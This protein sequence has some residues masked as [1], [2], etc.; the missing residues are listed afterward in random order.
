MARPKW[1]PI[2]LGIA[3]FVFI[4]GAGIVGTGIYL[5][6]RQVSMTS[7]TTEDPE[8][9]FAEARSKLA[10][11]KPYIEFEENDLE[12]KPIVHRENEREGRPPLNNLHVLIW[13]EREHKLVRLTLPFWIV[14]LGRSGDLRL[15]P[16]QTGM[17]DG[18]RL[19]V[20][21][22]D[23]ERNGP[24]LVLDVKGR[25]GERLLVWVD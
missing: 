16:E 14:R 23:L 21:A 18:L 13:D 15:D 17:R 12:S 3:I 2:A 19:S 6:S 11:Q 9:A 1:L 24:G 4:V 8:A 25:R 7:T 22:A 10:G 5:V 20:T